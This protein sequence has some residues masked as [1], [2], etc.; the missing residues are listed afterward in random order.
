MTNNPVKYTAIPSKE[1]R[2]CNK[3]PNEHDL[4]FYGS[5]M[6]GMDGLEQDAIATFQILIGPALNCGNNP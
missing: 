1:S 3:G 5:P 2:H 4:E 6:N